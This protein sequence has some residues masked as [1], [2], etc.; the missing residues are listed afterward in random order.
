MSVWRDIWKESLQANR[1][2]A[3]DEEN[4]QIEFH[5]LFKEYG[6][7]GM[8]HYALGEA[9]EY[10]KDFQKAVEE[11]TK[12]KELF[13]VPHWKK[14][15]AD[16]IERVSSNI[17]AEVFFNMND[18]ENLH[19]YAFQKIYEYVYLDDFVRYV[20]LS[21][22]SRANSEWPLSLVDFRSVLELQ[23]K[24]TFP[25]IVESVKYRNNDY[26]SLKELIYELKNNGY[27][28]RNISNSMHQIRCDGNLA[29]HDIEKYKHGYIREEDFDSIKNFLNVLD[30]FNTY[31]K[32]HQESD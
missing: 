26:A 5:Q 22:V 24:T 18:F 2:M 30:F 23:I 29:T 25:K 21:A 19:W 28:N 1:I 10:R 27:I 15:A 31:N 14:V 12:A 11:Y 16:T 6:D 20:C 3:E 7:D 8:L 9:W 4:G 32:N 13:P 17:T